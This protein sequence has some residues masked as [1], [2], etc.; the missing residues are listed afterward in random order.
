MDMIISRRSI[1]RASSTGFLFT[2]LGQTSAANDTNRER[3]PVFVHP[4]GSQ[5]KGAEAMRD[6]DGEVKFVYETFDFLAGELPSKRRNGLE[7]DRRV[8][9]VED[10][11]QVQIPEILNSITEILAFD[12]DDH[13]DQTLPWGVDRIDADEVTEYTGSGVD[14]GMLDTGVASHCDLTISGGTDCTGD[15]DGHDDNHG[16]GTHTTGIVS[17]DDSDIGVIGVAPDVNAYAVKVLTDT[18]V[19]LWSH[20]VCGIDWCRE[21]D[22]QVLSMSL[23]ADSMPESMYTAVEAASDDGHLLIGAAG[24][25]DN[26]EDGS[27]EEANV[28]QP[29]R[30]PA[31]IAVSAMDESDSDGTLLADYSSVGPEIE[32]MGPG[33][34][35]YSTYLGNDYAT[36]SGTSMACPHVS[37]VGA[38]IWEVLDS[39][40]PNVSDRD[41]IRNTLTDTAEPVLDTCEEGAG[42]V[43]AKAAV[44]EALKRT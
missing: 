8:S 35:I 32:I 42:L 24:N 23:G 29:A 38:L 2:A 11:G 5:A 12:C 33:T 15:I 13:P 21:N 22:I 25:S 7:H 30:H 44:E 39:D 41:T 31:V 6:H 43:D 16:H 18:G 9:F 34:R 10:D 4:A 14:V 40:G 3:E 37:G 19:G 28:T 27:C 1:L 20:V 36:L 17:A 26:D